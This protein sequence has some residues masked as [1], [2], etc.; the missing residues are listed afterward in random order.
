VHTRLYVSLLFFANYCFFFSVAPFYLDNNLV[1]Y[2]YMNE[3]IQSLTHGWTGR[4][5]SH[6]PISVSLF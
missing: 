2:V 6:D 4:L 1:L 5:M 3:Y